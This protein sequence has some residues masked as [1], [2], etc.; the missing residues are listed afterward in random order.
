[1][2]DGTNGDTVLEAVEATLAS[3]LIVA[4]GTVVRAQDVKGRHVALDVNVGGGRI[5]DLLR[6]AVPAS[7][8]PP[9]VG[10]IGLKTKLLIPAGD[11]DVIDKMRLDGEFVLS[12]ARFTSFNVQKRINVMSRKARG[13]EG[14]DEAPSVVS[15]LS[16]RFTMRNA[17]MT[18]SN[19]TFAVPGAVV[20]LAG[21]YGLRTEV[22]NFKGQLLLDA[23]LAQT[24]SGVK[25]VAARLIQPLFRR[26]GGGSRL[27]IKVAGTRS[28][29]AFGLDVR[30]ALLRGG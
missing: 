1:V 5:E 15:N 4:K 19:L 16:G 21:S 9:L 17:T 30:R 23:T 28:K 29:P 18:F 24:T 22:I 11:Q 14:D 12:Q 6:L 3:T 25:A 20:Q 27:P 8:H 2:V 10:R 26:P 7:K 13:D